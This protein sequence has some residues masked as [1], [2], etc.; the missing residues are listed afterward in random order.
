VD[1]VCFPLRLKVCIID[2]FMVILYN[3]IMKVV[4]MICLC[5]MLFMVA[6][7]AQA[8]SLNTSGSLVPLIRCGTEA[9]PDPCTLA[10]LLDLIQRTLNFSVKFVVFPVAGLFTMV[11]TILMR[12]SLSFEGDENA[13]QKHK[14]LAMKGVYI[15]IG[16]ALVWP[17][18]MLLFWAFLPNQS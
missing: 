5:V 14:D 3:D 8:I 2:I 1:L 7:P 11:S 17:F 9:N 16:L 10:D 4:F 15:I 12:F 13:Y 6:I 18:T